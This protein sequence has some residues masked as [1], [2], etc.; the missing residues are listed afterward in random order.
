MKLHPTNIGE[1]GDIERVVSTLVGLWDISRN[2]PIEKKNSNG[3]E[4]GDEG[5]IKRRIGAYKTGMYVEL[6]KARDIKPG[7]YEI[8]DY[9]GKTGK[10]KNRIVGDSI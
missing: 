10:I 7:S 1:A 9:N 6:L 4:S 8:L 5:E 2:K 3:K